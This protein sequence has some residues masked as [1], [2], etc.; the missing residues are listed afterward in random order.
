MKNPWVQEAPM[1][2]WRFVMAAVVSL[3]ALAGCGPRAPAPPSASDIGADNAG[4]RDAERVLNVYNWS[5]F[6]EP[7]VVADF[8]RA[9]GI[10]V[11]YDVYDTN[12]MMEVKLLA[13]RTNYDVVVPGG[14]FFEREVKAGVYRTLE[15]ARLPHLQG[16]D[17]G[18]VR[19]V[20]ALDP[21]QPPHGV[22]Y[23]WLISVGLG[24]DAHKLRARVPGAPVDSWRLL[25]DP[26]VVAHFADCGVS[27]LDSPDDVVGAVFALMGVDPNSESREALAKAETVL[28]AVRPYIRMVDS[29]R[30]FADLANGDV[31]LALGWSGDIAQARLRAGEA[32]K[33]V[34]IEYSVPKEGSFGIVDV[35]AIPR[36]APH[37]RNAHL[38][39]DYLLRPEVAAR[40]TMKVSYASGVAG[41]AA[42]VDAVY[43]NEAAIYPPAEVRARLA[44]MRARSPEFTRELMRAWTRFKTGQ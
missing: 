8:E 34:T 1:M 24:F 9:Y 7:Q 36:D 33:P 18:A 2:R 42:L 30:Y 3:W 23:M 26:L 40:N 44:P 19:A 16:E 31:C 14:S 29:A 27:V 11:H 15:P 22:A 20:A 38:F 13:G 4:S 43:R 12:E 25:F 39:I 10:K 17:P 37:P 41:A 28:H 35:F 21:S 32:G 6:I 5:E